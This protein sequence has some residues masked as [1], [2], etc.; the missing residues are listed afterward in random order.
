MD[1]PVEQGAEPAPR[2][3][4]AV[5]SS[6]LSTLLAATAAVTVLG[7]LLAVS[8]LASTPAVTASQGPMEHPVDS[9]QSRSICAYAA[10][11]SESRAADSD[12]WRRCRRSPG[13]GLMEHPV[14]RL[15][16]GPQ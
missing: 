12:H 5:S 14:E 3:L 2:S 6:Q 8:G 7:G 4:L 1:H 16:A 15:G 9:E 11:D 10:G 13:Q